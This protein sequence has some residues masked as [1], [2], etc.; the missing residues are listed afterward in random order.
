MATLIEDLGAAAD[1]LESYQVVAGKPDPIVSRLRAA[2]ARLREALE[3]GQ[4][5][6]L[7]RD[8]QRMAER[9]NGGPLKP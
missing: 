7:D 3:E 9:I 4:R 1:A 2:A 5:F 6:E 8:A